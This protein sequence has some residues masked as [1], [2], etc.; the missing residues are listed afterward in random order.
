MNISKVKLEGLFVDEL[1]ELQPNPGFM[2]LV[3]EHVLRAWEQRKA[4]VCGDEAFLLAQSIDIETYDR[5]GTNNWSSPTGFA[6][7][8]A[9]RSD[10]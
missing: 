3:K 1:K 10:P 9:R 7:S 4:G 5:H 8:E 6:A 2:R